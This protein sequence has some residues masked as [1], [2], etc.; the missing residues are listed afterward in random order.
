[1]SN[2]LLTTNL[3]PPPPEEGELTR[4][5]RLSD[6]LSALKNAHP[7]VARALEIEEERRVLWQKLTTPQITV[8]AQG[9][10]FPGGTTIWKFGTF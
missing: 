7:E 1:M 10:E 4:Y 8:N 6:E 9:A 2:N 5:M 3:N